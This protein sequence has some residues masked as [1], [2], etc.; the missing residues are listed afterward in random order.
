MVGARYAVPVGETGMAAI[1][2]KSYATGR[3]VRELA[4]EETG[5]SREQVDEIL[6]P[7]QQTIA[8]TGAGQAAGG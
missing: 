6:H 3:T 4:Y 5:L 2:K 1:A 8:G 7:H